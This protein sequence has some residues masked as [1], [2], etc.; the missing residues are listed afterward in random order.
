MA[1]DGAPPLYTMEMFER[2]F[3]VQRS[4]FNRV[5][6]SLNV[7]DQFSRKTN[8]LER[9]GM[10]P[11]HKIVGSFRMTTYGTASDSVSGIF[12]I[13]ESSMSR[14]TLHFLRAAE[15]ECSREYLRK[16]GEKY[17]RSILAINETRGFLG[18]LGGVD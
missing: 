4:V 16:S 12:R 3:Q 15:D 14:T 2:G 11:L 1:P 7:K 18:Y 5:D 10:H 9:N 17:L 6:D 13:S 8:P